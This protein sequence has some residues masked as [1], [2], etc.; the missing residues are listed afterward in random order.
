TMTLSHLQSKREAFMDEEGIIDV[1][2]ASC[3][4]TENCFSF[5]ESRKSVGKVLHLVAFVPVSAPK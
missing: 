2:Q 4:V 3:N 5:F 1:W